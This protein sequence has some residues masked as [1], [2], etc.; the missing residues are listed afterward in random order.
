MSSSSTQALKIYQE[1]LAMD[2]PDPL[3]Y[4]YSAAC[5]YYMGM[6]KEAE[7]SATQGP[8]CPLQTRILFHCAHKASTGQRG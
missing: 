4:I 7:A 3:Y 1:L 2:D 8:R 6:Y 5:Q